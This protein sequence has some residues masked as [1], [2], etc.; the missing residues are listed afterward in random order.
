MKL[1]YKIRDNANGKFSTGGGHPRWTTKGKV[2]STKAHVNSHLAMLVGCYGQ[3]HMYPSTVDVVEYELHEIE[4]D[5]SSIDHWLDAVKQHAAEKEK[6]RNERAAKYRENLRRQ[7]YEKL[8]AEF[9][10]S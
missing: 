5:V 2:W 8:K 10:P 6:K 7:E 1:V 9:E 3:R 4:S